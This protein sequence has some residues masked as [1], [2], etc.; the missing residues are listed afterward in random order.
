[1]SKLVTADYVGF[2]LVA[3]TAIVLCA[4]L[5]T[6]IG[7]KVKLEQT[8]ECDKKVASFNELLDKVLNPQAPAT[9]PETLA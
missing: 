5:F 1:M 9:P 3:I 6:F 4:F 2:V 7:L 8:K